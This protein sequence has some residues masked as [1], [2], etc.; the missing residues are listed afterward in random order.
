MSK[1]DSDAQKREKP[2]NVFNFDYVRDAKERPPQE[3]YEAIKERFA[4]ERDIR[5]GYRPP[6]TEIY[7]EMAGELANRG[8]RA[9]GVAVDSPPAAADSAGDAKALTPEEETA[10]LFRLPQRRVAG[11]ST[12]D[13][14]RPIA[15]GHG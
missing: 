2:Q 3:Y 1:S 11:F 4:E 6:G 7:Q 14:R 13:S 5:L 12:P 8:I 10:A 15:C 9:T